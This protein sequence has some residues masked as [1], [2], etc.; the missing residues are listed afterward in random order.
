[1]FQKMVEYASSVHANYTRDN[2]LDE[3]VSNTLL[4]ENIS[5]HKL[6]PSVISL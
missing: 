4:T 6:S 2:N 5:D 3:S 1:M